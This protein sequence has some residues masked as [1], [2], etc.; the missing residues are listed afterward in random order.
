MR[1]KSESDAE[2]SPSIAQA[3][4][5]P[6]VAVTAGRPLWEPPTDVLVTD[7]AVIVRLELAGTAPGDIKVRA[8]AG[9]VIISGLRR[10]PLGPA[11][12]RID[13]ME[14]A[15]GPFERIVP[16]PC[17]VGAERA[18]ARLADGLLEISLPLAGEQ[19]IGSTC[20]D[21]QICVPA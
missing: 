20:I 3:P 15:F 16:L 17:P 19:V 21:I 10:D 9:E 11:R 5:D 4:S 8:A 12:R 13:R 7:E 14:I 18:Y 1:L 6:A 2:A